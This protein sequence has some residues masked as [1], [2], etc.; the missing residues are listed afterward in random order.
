MKHITWLVGARAW[1][2]DWEHM[3]QHTSQSMSGARV[4]ARSESESTR[5]RAQ[6]RA[7]QQ[8]RLSA[9][10]NVGFRHFSMPPAKDC[11]KLSS[12]PRR[13]STLDQY[14]DARVTSS[15]AFETTHEPGTSL[16]WM[17][18]SKS[19]RHHAIQMTMRRKQIQ[20]TNKRTGWCA[21]VVSSFATAPPVLCSYCAQWS[22]KRC[23]HPLAS[24]SLSREF[25]VIREFGTREFGICTSRLK[26][27]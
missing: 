9:H 18:L 2:H 20:Y 14:P 25:V 19:L 8:C 23:V 10:S 6:V 15:D 7:S 12:N 27:N 21:V 16:Q 11:N 24:C 3:S 4:R 22:S 5:V 1:E 26:T 13:P 17:A